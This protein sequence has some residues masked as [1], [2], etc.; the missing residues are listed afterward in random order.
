[1]KAQYREEPMPT[2]ET[3]GPRDAA[4]WRRFKKVHGVGPG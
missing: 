3:L 1:M 4:E 2:F